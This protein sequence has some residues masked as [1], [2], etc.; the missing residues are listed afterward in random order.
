[1]YKAANKGHKDIVKFLINKMEEEQLLH[2]IDDFDQYSITMHHA[3]CN[4]SENQ[5]TRLCTC[6]V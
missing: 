3:Q 5:E 6:V 1:M 4:E 2:Y